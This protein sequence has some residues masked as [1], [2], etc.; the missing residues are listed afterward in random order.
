MNTEGATGD[1]PKY[2]AR[3]YA[4]ALGLIVPAHAAACVAGQAPLMSRIICRAGPGLLAGTGALG[5]G[6]S[7]VTGGIG[8]KILTKL[9]VE[10]EAFRSNRL[11]IDFY[12]QERERGYADTFETA[13]VVIANSV[14]FQHYYWTKSYGLVRSSVS[15]SLMS[16]AWMCISNFAYE[17]CKLV[18]GDVRRAFKTRD[19]SNE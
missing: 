13:A 3:D 18:H 6:L 2:S 15:A 16:I 12:D 14:L 19:A 5:F 11:L 7:V 8:D 1:G 4:H 17:F 9:L 10:S